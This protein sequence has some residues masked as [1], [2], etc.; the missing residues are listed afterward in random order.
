MNGVCEPLLVFTNTHPGRIYD[1]TRMVAAFP[2]V[3]FIFVKRNV[4]DI[5]LRIYMRHYNSGNAYSYDLKSARD[6]VLW[7]HEMMDLLA[8]KLPDIVRVVR[9]EDMIADPAAAVRVAADLCGFPMTDAPLPA[10]GDDRGCAEPYRQL[11]AAELER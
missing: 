3:R 1:A 10:V 6:Y 11:M 7:Y 8:E 9:Y 4:E 5:L 2:N